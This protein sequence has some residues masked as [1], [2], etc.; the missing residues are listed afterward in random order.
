MDSLD[1]GETLEY[2][3]GFMTRVYGMWNIYIFGLLFLYAP[4]HKEWG[5]DDNL[6]TGETA[7]DTLDINDNDDGAGEEVEFDVT[8]PAAA[9]EPSEMSSLTDFIRHQATD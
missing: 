8:G 2:T 7:R 3:S 6:S 4:S 5:N 1:L 9:S